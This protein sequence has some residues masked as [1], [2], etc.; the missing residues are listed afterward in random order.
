MEP[1]LLGSPGYA[2]AKPPRARENGPIEE[3]KRS[4]ETASRSLSTP[5]LRHRS[6]GVYFPIGSTEARTGGGDRI[7]MDTAAVIVSDRTYAPVRY[8]AEFFGYDVGWDGASRTV[9]IG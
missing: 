5:S 6:S 7:P 2:A 3:P 1:I 4:L 9:L 8:L